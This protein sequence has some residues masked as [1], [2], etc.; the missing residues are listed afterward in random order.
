MR[1]GHNFAHNIEDEIWRLYT[2]LPKDYMGKQ[3]LKL[4]AKISTNIIK[5][6]ENAI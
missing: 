1:P 5:N 6:I 3:I 4:G 2:N